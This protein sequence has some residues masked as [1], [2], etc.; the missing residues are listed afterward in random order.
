M[1]GVSSMMLDKIRNWTMNGPM[2]NDLMMPPDEPW[3]PSQFG[4]DASQWFDPDMLYG[5]QNPADYS[6][7]EGG[8]SWGAGS[9]APVYNYW[10]NQLPPDVLNEIYGIFTDVG[11]Y[12]GGGAQGEQ[13]AT[14]GL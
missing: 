3:D 14:L 13:L 1:E 9:Q 2:G 8:S 12:G 7:W 4:D 6:T 11:S 5:G 10:L